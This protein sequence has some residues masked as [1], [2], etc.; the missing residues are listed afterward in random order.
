MHHILTALSIDKTLRIEGS[1]RLRID[2]LSIGHE[3][4][5]I[6]SITQTE[7]ALVLEFSHHVG[8]LIREQVQELSFDQPLQVVD[9]VMTWYH[10]HHFLVLFI[11][12]VSLP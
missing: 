4:T 6:G 11:S 2:L 9:L 3:V 12:S 1:L 10:K 7:A 5:D 8:R